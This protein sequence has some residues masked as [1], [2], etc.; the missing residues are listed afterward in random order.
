MMHTSTLSF[1]V[2]TLDLE[3]DHKRWDARREVV[4]D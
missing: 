2:A 1:R 3:Q 4:I